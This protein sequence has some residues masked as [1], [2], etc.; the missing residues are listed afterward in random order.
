MSTEELTE[1]NNV[2][3]QQMFRKEEGSPKKE[4]RR[5]KFKALSEVCNF[6]LSET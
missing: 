5:P 4:D 2:I 6:A 3:F 1:K